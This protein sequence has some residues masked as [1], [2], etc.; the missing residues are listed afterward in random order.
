M[1]YSEEDEHRMV[2]DMIRSKMRK[3]QKHRARL[4]SGHCPSSS[5]AN[6]VSN[7]PGDK[8]S[9]LATN[10]Q[11][12]SMPNLFNETESKV[13]IEKPK[14]NQHAFEVPNG[15]CCGNEEQYANKRHPLL[16]Q[17][18]LIVDWD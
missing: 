13:T 7:K 18:S 10:R 1:W 16:V 17:E 11:A 4:M 9:K 6:A 3:E 8:G 14:N 2:R 12:Q 5:L 15:H